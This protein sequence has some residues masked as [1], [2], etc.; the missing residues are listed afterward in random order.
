M[1]SRAAGA[2]G[3]TQAKRANK[4]PSPKAINSHCVAINS[5]AGGTNGHRGS[6]K[7]A[8]ILCEKVKN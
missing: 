4:Q 5:R 3:R 1:F 6:D 8:G 7:I 2:K